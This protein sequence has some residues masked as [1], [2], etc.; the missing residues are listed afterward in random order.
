MWK[1]RNTILDLLFGL[2]IIPE[3]CG[4]IVATSDRLLSRDNLKVLH[5]RK[6]V[7]F[8]LQLFYWQAFR[9]HERVHWYLAAKYC[10]QPAR[11]RLKALTTKQM[12]TLQPLCTHS[13]LFS[14]QKQVNKT[15]R[16]LDS[17]VRWFFSAGM[18]PICWMQC[19]ASCR[20]GASFCSVSCAAEPPHPHIRPLLSHSQELIISVAETLI[21]CLGGKYIEKE[22]STL[23]IG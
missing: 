2:Y 4:F 17:E 16:C 15:H 18:S 11:G 9:H 13:C 6:A 12:N 3:N 14:L 7:L 21:D 19:A 23:F 5:D 1:T 20:R 10:S 22:C 8:L